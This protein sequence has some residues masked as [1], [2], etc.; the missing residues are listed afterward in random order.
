MACPTAV[1]QRAA[2]FVTV[3]VPFIE[4]N[5]EAGEPAAA[6][7]CGKA[8]AREAA[9][10]FPKLK[11]DARE[12]AAA[13]PKVKPDAREPA[14]AFPKAKPDAREPA[15]AFPKVKPDAREPAAAFPKVK[16]DAR[17]PAAAFPKVK[18][19]AREPA[20]ALSN[21]IASRPGDKASH[22]HLVLSLLE[23]HGFLPFA[24]ASRCHHD[25]DGEG[26]GFTNA[27]T[28]RDCVRLPAATPRSYTPQR[29]GPSAARR[30]NDASSRERPC[31][32]TPR[33][34]PPPRQGSLR[35]TTRT[36]TTIA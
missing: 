25:A 34:R 30:T 13:F 2:A 1:V 20:A 3:S 19:D 4:G 10:A 21:G 33:G 7:P 32:P 12:P 16:A 11:A 36:C 26:G 9:A 24:A 18:A 6:F 23:G 14:A 8:D 17:E 5:A 35:R 15:A 28:P 27:A 22:P 31:P 29:A